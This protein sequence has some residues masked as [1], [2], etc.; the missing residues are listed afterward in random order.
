M[1]NKLLK[2]I[3]YDLS[4]VPE[5]ELHKIIDGALEEY[6]VLKTIFDDDKRGH[7][8]INEKGKVF[9]SNHT[10]QT[11]IPRR[12]KLN[13]NDSSLYS[14]IPDPDIV[15]FVLSVIKKNDV[16]KYN[17]DF[18]I[19]V[20]EELRT[21]RVEFFPFSSD[22]KCYID[23][24]LSDISEYI[25]AQTRLRR[26]ESLASMT[27]MAAGVAHEIKNPLAAMTI[28][29]QLMRKSFQKKGSLTL[30]DADKFLTVIEEEIK[31]LNKIAVDFLFAV[32]PLDIELKLSSINEAIEDVLSFLEPEAEEKK[33]TVLSSLDKFLPYSMLDSR[34][35][36][37]ALL[38]IIQNAFQ[39]M[40]DGGNLTIKTKSEGDNII[41]R[42]GDTGSG[43]PS[44]KLQK[45]FE[46]Y[47]TTK[48]SGT[49]L[50][51][52]LVFKIIKAHNGDI[53]VFSEVGKG[54]TFEITLPIPISERKTL[55]DK[56]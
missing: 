53:H 47:F 41:I 50:G 19:Q 23:V 34:Q 6:D 25:R 37:Q 4:S 55:E 27:T 7:V 18:T 49:G 32:K 51:L 42:I 38:N 29:T 8:I 54:T 30:D 17:R 1:S 36:K 10:S 40:S 46:P 14:V 35:F 56:V 5:G 22:T 44:D 9:I 26:S 33:I 20:G 31:Q 11:I 13:K 12:T 28:H 43:I 21:I 24:I 3:K 2:K 52:T 39:A 16:K 45:I 48:A 15:P